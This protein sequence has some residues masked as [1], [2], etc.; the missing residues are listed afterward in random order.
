[1]GKIL[2]QILSVNYP[3]GSVYLG[4][5]IRNIYLCLHLC[6]I[7]IFVSIQLIVKIMGE[8]LKEI[9]RENKRENQKGLVSW[10]LNEMSFKEK[11]VSNI[12]HIESQQN[13]WVQSVNCFSKIGDFSWNGSERKRWKP[14]YRALKT[15]GCWGNEGREVVGC[16]GYEQGLWN[17]VLEFHSSLFRFLA[18]SSG[19]SWLFK[20]NLKLTLFKTDNNH[21]CLIGC[22]KDSES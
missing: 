16:H 9:C 8:I 11:M 4:C 1:M 21:T 14:D 13:K 6:F 7:F 20:V 5:E 17:Q 18:V 12:K 3:G 2:E 22:Y 15:T 10:K 19:M